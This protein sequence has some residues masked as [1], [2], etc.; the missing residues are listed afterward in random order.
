MKNIIKGKCVFTL[1]CYLVMLLLLANL[2][3]RY[4]KP[5]YSLQVMDLY[6]WK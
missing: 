3:L 5:N 2:T 1:C 6:K 4:C